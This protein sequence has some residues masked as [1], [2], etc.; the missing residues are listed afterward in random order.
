MFRIIQ[1]TGIHICIKWFCV[2]VFHSP[3]EEQ[4]SP[5]SKRGVGGSM[6]GVCGGWGVVDTANIF[7]LLVLTHFS[8]E[9]YSQD[10]E[11]EAE[12]QTPSMSIPD[13]GLLQQMPTN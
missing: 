12:N 8:T 5:F 3:W 4:T 11:D 6:R 13:L 1:H 9:H 10:W 2:L 7:S